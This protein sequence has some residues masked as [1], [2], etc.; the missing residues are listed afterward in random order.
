MPPPQ[1]LSHWISTL[2]RNKYAFI[3]GADF[4]T[5]LLH[6]GCSPAE[7][8]PEHLKETFANLAVNPAMDYKFAEEAAVHITD[9]TTPPTRLP[10]QPFILYEDDMKHPD[11]IEG[12]PRQYTERPSSYINGAFLRAYARFNFLLGGDAASCLPEWDADSPAMVVKQWPARTVRR[13]ADGVGEPSPEGVHQDG[14][15]IAMI[16]FVGRDNVMKGTGRNR[17]WSLDQPLGNHTDEHNTTNLAPGRLKGRQ[18]RRRRDDGSPCDAKRLRLWVAEALLLQHSRPPRPPSRRRRV[19]PERSC[20]PQ[21]VPQHARNRAHVLREAGNHRWDVELRLAHGPRR[22]R[23][24]VRAPERAKSELRAAR[25][26]AAKAQTARLEPV[27]LHASLTAILG[28]RAFRVAPFEPVLLSPS[29][30]ECFCN[31]LLVYLV[32]HSE[33]N[34]QFFHYVI[35]Y[36]EE[37][38]WEK[39][40]LETFENCCQTSAPRVEACDAKRAVWGKTG[41]TRSSVASMRRYPSLLSPLSPREATG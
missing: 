39:R 14:C 23:E 12:K 34:K 9:L 11:K 25:K 35:I 21:R 40:G 19:R 26:G 3:P 4:K 16:T 41:A 18:S 22:P 17:V 30:F 27:V 24:H 36:P 5:I 29:R 33:C 1:V 10:I 38:A 31:A 6:L 8:A 7:L 2:K 28:W 15:E 20:A 32:L 37:R 13:A